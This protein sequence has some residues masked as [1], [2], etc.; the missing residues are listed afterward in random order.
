[1]IDHKAANGEILLDL[2]QQRPMQESCNVNQPRSKVN[3]CPLRA[4]AVKVAGKQV[5]D[6][7][8]D[9]VR[10]VVPLG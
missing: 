10:D 3:V 2:R 7:E 9:A 5:C 4:D 8:L 6:H 1:M